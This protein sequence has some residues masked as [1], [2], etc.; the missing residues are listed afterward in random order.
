M[1]RFFLQNYKQKIR[2]I[3]SNFDSVSYT[4]VNTQY[5]ASFWTLY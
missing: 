2:T 1:I 4:I 3:Q 5:W